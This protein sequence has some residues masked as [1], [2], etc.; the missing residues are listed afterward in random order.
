MEAGTSLNN[1][2]KLDYT[3]ESPAAR[4]ELVKQIIDSLPPEKL[5]PH[6]LEVLSNY[7]IFAMT[8]EEKKN[9]KINTENRM[10]TINKREMSF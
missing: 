8:K 6:Y 9:K 1:T 3:I 5:T 7:I 4:N 2:L 10:V